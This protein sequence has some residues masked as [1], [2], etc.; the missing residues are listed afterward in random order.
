MHA[1]GSG[2]LS[3]LLL[4]KFADFLFLTET[5][6][7]KERGLSNKRSLLVFATSWWAPFITI[8]ILVVVSVDRVYGIPSGGSL[9]IPKDVGVIQMLVLVALPMLAAGIYAMLSVQANSTTKRGNQ[10]IKELNTEEL[11]ALKSDLLS[12]DVQAH[13]LTNKNEVR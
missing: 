5:S 6:Q 9:A 4:G 8:F 13:V 11:G 10:K 2:K 12:E 7:K 3:S 1:N